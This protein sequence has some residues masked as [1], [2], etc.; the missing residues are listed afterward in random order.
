M[1][2]RIAAP[3]LVSLVVLGCGSADPGQAACD[4]YRF[5]EAAWDADSER[6]GSDDLTD[7]QR[8]ADDLIRCRTLLGLPKREVRA[9]LGPPGAE[10]NR[11]MWL[12]IVGPERGPIKTRPETLQVR[13]GPAGRVRDARLS[14]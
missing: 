14:D 11:R 8:I 10:S 3:A 1:D 12:W 13:F 4:R 6:P 2:R 7:R 5:D 9:M